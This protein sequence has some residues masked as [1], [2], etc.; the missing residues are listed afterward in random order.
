MRGEANTERRRGDASGVGVRP[1]EL[2]DLPALLEIYNHYVETTHITFDVEPFTP[3]ILGTKVIA[4]FTATSLPGT[5]TLWVALYGTG[6]L[7]A[8]GWNLARARP[9]R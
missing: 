1:A 9:A 2:A 7:V 3:A 6:L 5:G 4:N 8:L